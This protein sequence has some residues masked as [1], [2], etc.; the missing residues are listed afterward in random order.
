LEITDNFSADIAIGRKEIMKVLHVGHW[1]TVRNWKRAYKLPLRYLPN[2]K[3]M[4][5]QSEVRSW[6]ITY[7]DLKKDIS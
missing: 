5:I 7:S 1:D 4:I 3:P 2:G 6:M